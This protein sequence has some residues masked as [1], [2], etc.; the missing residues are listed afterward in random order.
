MRRAECIE[1]G[2]AIIVPDLLAFRIC[3]D[4]DADNREAVLELARDIASSDPRLAELLC[5]LSG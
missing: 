4:C 3:D 2:R 5:K 1:C